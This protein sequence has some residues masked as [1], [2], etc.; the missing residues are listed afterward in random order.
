MIELVFWSFV[1]TLPLLLLS[2]G[3]RT[4]SILAEVFA[5]YGDRRVGVD[6]HIE[7]TF[8]CVSRGISRPESFGHGI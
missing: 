4:L 8:Q 5:G 3:V 6:R 1:I 2:V 7:P